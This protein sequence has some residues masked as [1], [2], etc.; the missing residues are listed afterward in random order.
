M[1]TA[2]Y[3]I[4]TFPEKCTGCRR[5]ELGCYYEHTGAFSIGQAY[6]VVVEDDYATKSITF[7]GKCDGCGVCVQYCV[8][9]ALRLKRKEQ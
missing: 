7:G 2:K 8:Y 3:A 4:L 1:A 9:G 5:C 6:I